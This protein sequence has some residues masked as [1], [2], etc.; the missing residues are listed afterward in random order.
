MA[1]ASNPSFDHP[2]FLSADYGVVGTG[3]II[4][5]S[6]VS[7]SDSGFLAIKSFE[8]NIFDAYTSATVF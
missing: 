6:Y 2:I 8:H 7:F 3:A 4:N 1:T 5:P